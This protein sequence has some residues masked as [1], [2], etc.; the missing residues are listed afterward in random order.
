[1]SRA[2][3]LFWLLAT[4]FWL[5]VFVSGCTSA[6]QSGKNTALDAVDLVSMTDDMAA[7]IVADPEVQDAIAKDG[8]LKVVVQPVVNMMEGEILPR[9]PSEAFTGRVRTLLSRHSPGKFLWVMNRDAWYRLRQ[10]ELEGVDPGPAPEAVNP[11]YA[12]TAIFSSL[13]EDNTKLRK[14]SYLCVYQL[15][16]LSDRTILWTDKYI[17]EKK[18]VK[19][20]LD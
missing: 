11:K 7:K 20:F 8:Q 9:G 2:T 17:V 18:A 12:L 10:Q 15:T 6:V 16:N 19:G 5:L 3:H 14:S 4:G 1:M 13:T